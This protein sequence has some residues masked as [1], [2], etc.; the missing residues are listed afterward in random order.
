MGI[1]GGPPRVNTDL[2]RQKGGKRPE[3]ETSLRTEI[4]D[5]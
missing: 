4:Q 3:K 2:A 1:F 5:L